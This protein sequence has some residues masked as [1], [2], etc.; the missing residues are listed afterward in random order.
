VWVN[1]LVRG[2]K[3]SGFCEMKSSWLTGPLPTG[4]RQ[5]VGVGRGQDALALA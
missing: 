3:A 1:A 4:V 5:I 2:D